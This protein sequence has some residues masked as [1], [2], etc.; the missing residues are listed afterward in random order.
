MWLINVAC[1]FAFLTFRLNYVWEKHGRRAET[2]EEEKNRERQRERRRNKTEEQRKAERER[3]REMR[4]N[5]S[6]EQRYGGDVQISSL[7]LLSFAT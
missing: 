1:S 2:K 7:F 5:S 3:L 6:E 4:K